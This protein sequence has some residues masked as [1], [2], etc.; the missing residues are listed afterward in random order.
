MLELGKIGYRG[1]WK[2]TKGILISKIET[3]TNNYKPFQK[4]PGYIFRL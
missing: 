4:N 1:D 2:D 3:I